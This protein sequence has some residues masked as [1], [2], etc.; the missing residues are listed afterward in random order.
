M[1]KYYKTDGYPARDSTHGRY[2]PCWVNFGHFPKCLH[3]WIVAGTVVPR[4]AWT[5]R[6]DESANTFPTGKNNRQVTAPEKT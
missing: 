4:N 1:A 5:G 3:T 2:R 6:N